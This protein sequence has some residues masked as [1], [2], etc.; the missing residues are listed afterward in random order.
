MDI[1][2]IFRKKLLSLGE[3]ARDKDLEGIWVPDDLT[4][5]E[6]DGCIHS[7]FREK[8]KEYVRA[9]QGTQYFEYLLGK[10]F[11]KAGFQRFDEPLRILDICS[12]AG[13]SVVPLLAM[14]PQAEVIASDLSVELLA[15]LKQLLLSQG[16]ADRC[17]LVQMNAER[18]DFE[19]G[20]VDLVVG[21]AALHHLFRP[22]LTIASCARILR[23]GGLAVFF[24]P[25]ETGFMY[26]KLLY[27]EILADPRAGEID[28]AVRLFLEEMLIDINR[29]TG[30]DKS[31]PIFKQ[32]DDK[33][34]FTAD[35]FREHSRRYG[36]RDCTI[37]PLSTGTREFEDKLGVILRL[38]LDRKPEALPDWAWEYA[39][40]RD[41][42]LLASGRC[43]WIY[44]GGA[45]LQK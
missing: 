27:Q 21:A 32:V 29:R 4:P 33:W 16:T 26:M 40:S 36:F 38:G 11:E 12:G 24:E 5:A 3:L 7:L 23:P 41:R 19:D 43:D 10:A 31:D 14:F 30:E 6:V 2:T 35:Y 28:A 44:D 1:R 13:N 34:F 39:R 45:L 9:Y 22:D 17:T 18:L 37:Y 8:A 42:E 25:F 15:M 20:A